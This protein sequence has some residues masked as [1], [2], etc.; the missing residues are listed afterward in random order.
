MSLL[1]LQR[2]FIGLTGIVMH[3]YCPSVHM[4]DAC[5]EDVREVALVFIFI[6]L[7]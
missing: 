4:S 2:P 5:F 1:P 6:F 3:D 7:L